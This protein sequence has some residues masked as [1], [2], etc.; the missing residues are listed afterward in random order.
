MTFD[1]QAHP[2]I[3]RLDASGLTGRVS[4]VEGANTAD[5]LVVPV[6]HGIT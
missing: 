4:S 2:A 1:E 5:V 3:V 6:H